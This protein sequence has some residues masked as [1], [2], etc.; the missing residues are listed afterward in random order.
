MIAGMTSA[1][2]PDEIRTSLPMHYKTQD[3]MVEIPGSAASAHEVVWHHT[4]VEGLLG[5]V[6]NREL[7]AS[8]PA[9]L[10][11]ASEMLYGSRVLSGCWA[12][13]RT[14]GPSG[15]NLVSVEAIDRILGSDG[16]SLARRSVYFLCAT[17]NDDSL[18]QWMHYSGRQGYAVGLRTVLN[19]AATQYDVP[20]ADRELFLAS[21]VGGRWMDVIYE[22]KDQ[23]EVSRA[24]LLFCATHMGDLGSVKDCEV[25]ISQFLAGLAA[26]LKHPSFE[27]EREVRFILGRTPH[28]REKFRPGPRGIVPYL[29]VRRSSRARGCHDG[30][31]REPL[32]ISSVR[33][34]PANADEREAIGDAVRRLLDANDLR[35]AEVFHSEVPYRF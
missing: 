12:D 26:Q 35:Q 33:C 30:E 16:E 24:M 23:R 32:P 11:D 31:V 22:P 18:N 7:W 19:Y 15:V 27:A 3:K 9:G 13:L 34:G 8:S 20:T 25:R 17:A 2:P 1:T 6:Q 21:D 4:T 14:E 28:D 10:N 5:M 29:E